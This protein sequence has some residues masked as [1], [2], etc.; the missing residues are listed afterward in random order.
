MR[1]RGALVSFGCI[2]AVAIGAKTFDVI[3]AAAPDRPAAAGAKP[4]MALS[5]AALQRDSLIEDEALAAP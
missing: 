4:M 2:G 5:Y 1:V 3:F